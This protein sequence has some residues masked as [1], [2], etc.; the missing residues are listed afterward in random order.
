MDTSARPHSERRLTHERAVRV[1]LVLWS[2]DVLMMLLHAIYLLTTTTPP[3]GRLSHDLLAIDQDRGLAEWYG[4][5]KLSVVV[6]G[7]LI[8]AVRHRSRAM[9]A[10]AAAFGYVLLDDAMLVHEALGSS[11]ASA[12]SFP[13]VLGLR[14]Q[15]LGELLVWLAA[16]LVLGTA[17]LVAHRRS[18]GAERRTSLA[19]GVLFGLLIFCGLVLDMVHQALG[20]NRWLNA[21]LTLAED[22]GELLVVSVVVFVVVSSRWAPHSP[23]DARRAEQ[24]P[25]RRSTA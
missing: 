1:L 14:E 7:L 18:Q 5:V 9:L 20:G 2:L 11:L 3:A 24:Q 21:L 23:Q 25:A 6:V 15:D 10:W 13:S 4:Y 8:W 17:V 12:V 22:G 19:L 16:G